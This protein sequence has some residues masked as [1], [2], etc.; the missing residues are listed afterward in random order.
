MIDAR[1]KGPLREPLIDGHSIDSRGGNARVPL[2]RVVFN[3]VNCTFGTGFFLGLHRGNLLP[4]LLTTAEPIASIMQKDS[5]E[6]HRRPI[7]TKSGGSV[8]VSVL[9]ITHQVTGNRCA[10]QLFG[11]ATAPDKHFG[12]QVIV[13]LHQLRIVRTESSFEISAQ[14][15][16]DSYRRV[17]EQNRHLKN[18]F[19]CPV[20]HGIFNLQRDA[21]KL[22]R[23]RP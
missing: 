6:R 12:V 14:Q 3:V 17:D 10:H 7:H 16:P 21:S 13:D 18:G 22:L 23:Q 9:A 15:G 8:S 11:D 4:L 20:I 2:H 19:L 1:M 5:S